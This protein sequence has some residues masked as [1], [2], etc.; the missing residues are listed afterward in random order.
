LFGIPLD[1]NACCFHGD[2]H[3][4]DVADDGSRLVFVS[5]GADGE[6]VISA[7][8]DGSNLVDL[9]GGLSYAMR[10]AISGDGALVAYD[11][12][13]AGVDQN[14][15][16]VTPFGDVSPHVL[17]AA[18]PYSG[19]LEPFQLTQTGSKLLVSS[20]GLLFDTAS[21]DAE[22]LGASISGVGGNHEAVLTDGLPRGT[23]D[24][25][26]EQFLYVM[27]TVR[28]A[29]CANQ[30]EQL[31][32]MTIDPVDLGSAPVISNGSIAPASILPEY[33]SEAVISASVSTEGQV[34]G[35]GFSAL[36]GS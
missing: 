1:P 17:V 4:L 34:L 7:N 15:V 22:L 3:P 29:D 10:V 11:V 36:L 33:G 25:A 31:A 5:Y 13:P 9:R 16:I 18:M 19:Y 20:N 12:T 6:H 2:G 35:V 24:D 30:Q 23:M 21:G 32:T 26:G 28:C 27:R 14:E 8:G